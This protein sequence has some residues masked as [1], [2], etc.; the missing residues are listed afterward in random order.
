M[1]G[2]GSLDISEEGPR[3]SPAL[4]AYEENM[5][6]DKLI[7]SA[8]T[9]RSV[10]AAT[11]EQP[12]SSKQ[13]HTSLSDSEPEERVISNKRKRVRSRVKSTASGKETPPLR[14]HCTYSDCRVICSSNPSLSRHIETHK[15]RGSYA[16]IRCEA[17]QRSLSNEFS[18]QRHILNSKP[19]SRCHQMRVYSVMCSEMEV[20]TT[21]R[22]YPKRA[23][24]I[25][26][27]DSGQWKEN[28][29][30]NI[31]ST[32][33]ST[34]KSG[35]KP[36]TKKFAVAPTATEAKVTVKVSEV[37]Q[38]PSAPSHLE[39]DHPSHT[40][41]AFVKSDTQL[42]APVGYHYSMTVNADHH[43]SQRR[44]ELRHTIE[45]TVDHFL[46]SM[47]AITENGKLAH[48]DLAGSKVG[49]IA[50]G[51]ENVILVASATRSSRMK[52]RL[53]NVLMNLLL[54]SKVLVYAMYMVL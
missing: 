51:A 16:P 38:V 50:F 41:D 18:V 31:P 39:N 17:C 20:E 35:S 34:F 8:P 32:L 21:V 54:Q 14:L 37:T 15:W 42:A 12:C 3:Q 46:T 24:A 49:R 43:L 48:V 5:Y 23:H 36:S 52:A 1:S 22:F 25:S 53:S 4:V 9:V 7:V 26:N 45:S 29:L 10:T 13:N 2:Q 40:F 28:Q 6:H 47:S 44:N 27:Q 30:T 33:K 19:T 11:V